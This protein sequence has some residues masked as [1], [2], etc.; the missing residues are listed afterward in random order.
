MSYAAAEREA[1]AI[2]AERE[3]LYDMRTFAVDERVCE[4]GK[5][6]IVR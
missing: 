5:D 2:G 3:K 6:S 1:L 4:D